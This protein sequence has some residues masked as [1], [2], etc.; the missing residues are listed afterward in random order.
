MRWAMNDQYGQKILS[1]Y[2]DL[3]AFARTYEPPALSSKRGLTMSEYNEIM[4]RI[5]ELND[6][7]TRLTV[8]S[9]VTYGFIDSNMPEWARDTVRKMTRVPDR[10]NPLLRGDENGNLQLSNDMLRLF[11]ILDRAGVFDG[12]Y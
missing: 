5:D 2:G 1:M 8:N 3:L 4:G 6:R 10:D 7:L 12:I 9:R 11:V